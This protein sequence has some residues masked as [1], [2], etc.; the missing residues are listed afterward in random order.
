[1]KHHQIMR[2]VILM[3]ALLAIMGCNRQPEVF[4]FTI[5]GT[6]SGLDSGELYLLESLRTGD[7]IVIPVENN[8]FEYTGT[9]FFM[10]STL[11]YDYDMEKYFMLVIEP[12][13]IYLELDWDSMGNSNVASGDHNIALRKA[14]KE[15]Y[16]LFEEDYVDMDVLIRGWLL[17][18]SD[19]FLSISALKSW[20]SFDDFLEIDE[21]EEFLNSVKDKKIRK[22]L[23]FIELY[24]IYSGKKERLS[25]EGNLAMDFRL[26]DTDGILVD[27]NSVSK[28]KLTYVEK[29][30]SWCGNTTNESRKLKT[31]YEKYKDYGFEIITV[32]P[33]S[34]LHRWQQWLEEERFPWVNLVELDSEVYKHGLSYSSMLFANGNYLV[35]EEGVII[36]TGLTSGQLAELIMQHFE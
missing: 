20:E 23:D 33:E 32:V 26:F 14:N 30:G 27:F 25:S 21:L 15:F 36:A 7:E 11:I 34:K 1:M 8:Y 16:A 9:S 6:I 18:N 29:S 5:R 19:N 17:E 13:E 4:E 3:L 10:Y 28:G 12:G 24:S 31:V 2:N 22:S 35:D